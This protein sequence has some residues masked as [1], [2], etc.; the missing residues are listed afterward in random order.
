M[1]VEEFNRNTPRHLTNIVKSGEPQRVTRRRQ[2]WVTVVP[3]DLFADLLAVAGEAGARVL[4][5]HQA[6]AERRAL[7]TAQQE[8]TEEAVA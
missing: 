1:H 7:E 6:R 3:D 8:V 5:E 2:P 4:A